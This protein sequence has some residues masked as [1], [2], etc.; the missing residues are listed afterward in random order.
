MWVGPSSRCIS[1]M[2]ENTGRSG[3]PVQKVGG[4]AGRSPSEAAAAALC[5]EH[6]LHAR[7]DRVGVDAGR[8]R[9][10]QERRE[11]VEQHVRGV[12]AGLRQRALAEDAGLDVG[13]AQLDVDLLLDVVGRAFLDHQHR[14]LAGAERR[15]PPPAP[16]DRR[17]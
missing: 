9:L 4:R 6:L 2:A 17:S 1:L 11:P 13:A 15:A 12:V 5:A 8:P 10:A 7:G 16:A 3:Q 14:A